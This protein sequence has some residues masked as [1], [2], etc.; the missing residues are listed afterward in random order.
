MAEVNAVGN[1]LTAWIAQLKTDQNAPGTL[2]PCPKCGVP[3][4][5]RSDYIRCCPCGLNWLPGE[6]MDKDPRLTRKQIGY[7][8]KETKAVT[9][10]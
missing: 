5:Q 7:Q 10:D 4:C 8:A 9:K 3:R 2:E 1:D 6:N